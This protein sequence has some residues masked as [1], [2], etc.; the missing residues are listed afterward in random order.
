[1]LKSHHLIGMIAITLAITSC[2][3]KP[4]SPPQE[5][6]EETKARYDKLLACKPDK[7]LSKGEL[8]EKAMVQ[9][10]QK[11]TDYAFRAD[12]NAY[13]SEMEKPKLY[14]NKLAGNEYQFKCGLTYH[15]D[16]TPDKVT[17][18]I[19]YP[20]QV[21]QFDDLNDFYFGDDKESKNKN[22]YDFIKNNNA[23]VYR[24][25]KQP[26]IYTKEHYNKDVDFMVRHSIDR[27]R[28]YPKDCCKLLNYQEVL[29]QEKNG[30]FYYSGWSR[31]LVSKEHLSKHHFLSI[32]TIETRFHDNTVEDTYFLYPITHCGKIL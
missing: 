1:M 5:T 21:Y 28:I 12:Y 20:Y 26:P 3:K 31:S 13:E 14:R 25:D 29:S 24:W 23:Q 32:K 17:N 16:G 10:W 4:Y 18:D 9:Y 30:V 2:E 11:K 22:I 15:A 27:V 7:P 8:Y 19:C 6:K